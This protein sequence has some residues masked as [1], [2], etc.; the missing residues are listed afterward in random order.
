MTTSVDAGGKNNAPLKED[1]IFELVKDRKNAKWNEAKRGGEC[2]L[3]WK[4]RGDDYEKPQTI[5]IAFNK[6]PGCCNMVTYVVYRFLR[7][8]FVS[9]WFYFFPIIV[10]TA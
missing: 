10:M 3:W 2:C 1:P 4:K 6:R 5:R 7:L 9:I 8:L